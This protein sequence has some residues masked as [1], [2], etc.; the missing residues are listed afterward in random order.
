MAIV[1]TV[2]IGLLS[3]FFLFA[4]SIKVLGWQKFIFE[5]QMAFMQKY[6]LNRQILCLIGLVEL[7]AAMLIWLQSS[8]WGPIGALALLLTSVGALYF[9]FRYDSWKDAVPAM[10][11]FILSTLVVYSGLDVLLALVQY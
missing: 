10:V 7:T 4:G 6:G 1:M 11:T 5:T 9:H 3:F 8:I 2:L